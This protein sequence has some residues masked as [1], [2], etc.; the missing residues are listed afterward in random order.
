MFRSSNLRQ[1]DYCSRVDDQNLLF[2]KTDS[3]EGIVL[4]SERL[5]HIVTFSL[6]M[7]YLASKFFRIWF[8]KVQL[9]YNVYGQ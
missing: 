1:V 6:T 9:Q 5:C 2:N 3:I 4:A 8:L 7:F